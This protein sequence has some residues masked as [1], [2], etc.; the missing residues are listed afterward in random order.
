M[1]EMS[2]GLITIYNM[3]SVGH[4]LMWNNVSFMKNLHQ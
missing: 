4:Y 1:L 2:R 3:Q